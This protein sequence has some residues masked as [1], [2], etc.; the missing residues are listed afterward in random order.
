MEFIKKLNF[1]NRL[2][3][4]LLFPIM[5]VLFFA[6][7]GIA[8]KTK[9]AK[10]MEFVG[11][12]ALMA[13]KLS[14]LVHET[15][16]ERGATAVFMGSKGVRF[17]SEL[18]AQRVDT[19]R[20]LSQLNKFLPQFEYQQYGSSFADKLAQ[21]N[22]SLSQLTAF[23]KSVDTLSIDVEQ[24]INHYSAINKLCLDLFALL[25][26]LSTN[27]KISVLG[28]AYVNFLKGKERAG[29]ERAV[30]SS[31]LSSGKSN[32]KLLKQ[33]LSLG[34]QQQIHF[35]NFL[36][37]APIERVQ[38][39]QAFQRSKISKAV[40]QNRKDIVEQAASNARQQLLTKL[41]AGIGYGGVIHSFKNYVLRLD[42]MYQQQFLL[43]Y[44]ELMATLKA[45]STLTDVTAEEIALVNTI[46]AVFDQYFEAVAQVE[47]I[48]ALNSSIQSLD[49]LLR[50]NDE[51]AIVAL[52]RLSEITAAINFK[53]DAKV[54]FNNATERI[55]GLKDIEDSISA[56]LVAIAAQNKTDAIKS[57]VFYGCFILFVFTITYLLTTKL[58]RSRKIL[59]KKESELSLAR[60]EL[61]QSE[62]IASLGRMVAGFAH[63]VNTPIGIAVGAVSQAQQSL[64]HFNDMLQQDEVEEQALLDNIDTM[65]KVSALAMSNLNRAARLVKSF[66][67]TS[68]D[69]ASEQKRHYNL[70]SAIEDVVYTLNSKLSKSNIKVEVDC[71]AN[72]QIY[73]QPGR[74]D[75]LLTNLI[76]NSYLH[77]FENG[78][79]SGNIHICAAITDDNVTLTYTDNGRGMQQATVEQIFEPFFTTNRADGSGLGMYICYTIV[80]NDMHGIIRCNSTPG[81]G[82]VFEVVFPVKVV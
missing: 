67:R 54:W 17:Q 29:I 44:R 77:G 55:N 75:Q 59:N 24:A 32:T 7:V 53:V 18:I 9:A 11:Q 64:E 80:V 47:P 48:V 13:T 10:D 71:I 30:V 20:Q 45:Y 73:G 79:R 57:L 56:D 19:D 8:D 28:N 38:Q 69:Q 39:Y 58:H 33:A 31:I 3:L 23:R 37:A 36:L 74:F 76:L 65:S 46:A 62:K 66:K 1:T 78:T 26:N 82:V 43:H 35:E 49:N 63:E 21:V 51:P 15:Q 50:I 41:Y 52:K 27:S 42:T 4:M 72:A 34:I 70:K 81:Q 14:A 22:Q 12:L 61:V 16:K 5:G 2:Y 25:P 6:I 40:E 60:E 68:I